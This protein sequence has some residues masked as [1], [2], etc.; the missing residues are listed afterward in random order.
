MHITPTS[1]KE[2]AYTVRPR[3]PSPTSSDDG[4]LTH[5]QY[6]LYVT[7]FYALEEEHDDDDDIFK[8]PFDVKDS[9]ESNKENYPPPPLPLRAPIHVQK[10][11]TSAPTIGSE[12]RA[13]IDMKESRSMGLTGVYD[14]YK[15]NVTLCWGKLAR[16][17]Q[18]KSLKWC[19]KNVN[20]SSLSNASKSTMS[21]NRS[22]MDIKMRSGYFANSTGMI[23]SYAYIS[24]KSDIQSRLSTW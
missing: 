11:N 20:A 23:A 3:P 14:R 24:M 4:K 15:M 18:A 5:V 2:N 19:H 7:I 9:K 13:S 17:D 21:T 8:R 22:R 12:I 10:G 6:R 16:V 1:R